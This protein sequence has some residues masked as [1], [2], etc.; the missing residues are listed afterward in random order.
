VGRAEIELYTFSPGTQQSLI[1]WVHVDFCLNDAQTHNLASHRLDVFSTF[2]IPITCTCTGAN[3]CV[4][5]N[6]YA[7]FNGNVAILVLAPTF[8]DHYNF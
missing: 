8:L 1:V 4:Q 3:Q 2:M 5:I 7:A 6:V